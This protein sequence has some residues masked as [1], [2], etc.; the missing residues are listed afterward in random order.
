M[1]SEERMNGYIDQIGS[2]VH[3]GSKIRFNYSSIDK[4]LIKDQLILIKLPN[5]C[6]LGISKCKH[7]ALR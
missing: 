3:F 4:F 7:Y 1:I 6:Q 2:V 5:V